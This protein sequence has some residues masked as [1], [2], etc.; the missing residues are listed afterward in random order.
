NVHHGVNAAVQ[1]VG[2][3][4]HVVYR[5]EMG[6]VDGRRF[7]RHETTDRSM[8]GFGIE[9]GRRRRGN[10]ERAVVVV[11]FAIRQAES[12]TTEDVSGFGVV[13]GVV[14]AGVAGGVQAAQQASGEV[15]LVAVRRL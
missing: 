6:Q 8:Q 2:Q 11:Q 9:R 1:V 3:A 4:L 7:Q 15:D 12:V 14:V 13:D 10:D 5:A